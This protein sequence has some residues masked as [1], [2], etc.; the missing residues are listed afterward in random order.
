M[1]TTPKHYQQ[2]QPE[3]GVTIGSLKQQN[4]GV[5]AIACVLK[6]SASAI[7]RELGRIS[8]ADHYGSG[9]AHQACQYWRR[10]SRPRQKLHV[11]SVLFGVVRHFLQQGW[12]PEQ[13]ALAQA[14]FMSIA[15]HT[16]PSTTASTP[17]RSAN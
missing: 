15:C 12:S 7:S 10:Q 3:E 2:L 9:Q 8:T 6:L 16:K 4:Y 5:R 14:A 11:D 13:I 1:E 17:N